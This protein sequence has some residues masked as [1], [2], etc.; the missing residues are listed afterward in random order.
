MKYFKEKELQEIARENSKTI[1]IRTYNNG[2][3]NDERREATPEEQENIYKL[4]YAGLLAINF[5]HGK[6]YQGVMDACEYAGHMFLPEGTNC[7]D[8]IYLPLFYFWH[9]NKDSED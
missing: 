2:N 1:V 6:E 4:L 5:K 7:Y 3:S 8:T 9:N